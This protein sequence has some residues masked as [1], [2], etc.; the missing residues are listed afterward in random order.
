M[1]LSTM[2]IKPLRLMF[3]IFAGSSS[4]PRSAT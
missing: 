3:A 4:P 1:V 2:Q